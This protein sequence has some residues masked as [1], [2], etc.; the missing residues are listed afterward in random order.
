MRELA[1]SNLAVE[2]VNILNDKGVFTDGCKP[3]YYTFQ[4]QNDVFVK[5][6]LTNGY[7]GG[8]LK[9]I[10][11]FFDGY[12]AIYS[13]YD[14]DRFTIQEVFQYMKDNVVDRHDDE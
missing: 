10:G 13:V 1:M 8:E 9:F 11:K 5:A 12:G 14:S 3:K 2:I 7:I 4:N 6:M